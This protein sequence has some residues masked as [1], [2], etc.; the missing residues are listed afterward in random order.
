MLATCARPERDVANGIDA[1]FAMG[2]GATVN[3]SSLATFPWDRVCVI[4]PYTP[5][6]T[7]DEMLGFD[8]EYS[9][10]D[11]DS[12]YEFLFVSG[13]SVRTVFYRARGGAIQLGGSGMPTCYPRSTARF[14]VTSAS[15]DSTSLILQ[16]LRLSE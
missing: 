9:P 6:R 3:I 2:I 13:K 8:I 16:P 11:Y 10:T 14:I 4:G 15:P 12:D 1:A 5:D 7:V